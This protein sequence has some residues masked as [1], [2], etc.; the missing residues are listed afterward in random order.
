MEERKKRER[1]KN[2]RKKDYAV[3]WERRA[4]L[5]K[6]EQKKT[7]NKHTDNQLDVISK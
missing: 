6:N 3:I 2:K 7:T 4:E 5:K 1:R